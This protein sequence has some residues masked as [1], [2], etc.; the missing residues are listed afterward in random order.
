MILLIGMKI[1]PFAQVPKSGFDAMR[2]G[3]FKGRRSSIVKCIDD[4]RRHDARLRNVLA[5]RRVK[6]SV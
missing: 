6:C 1:A 2:A 4:I 5:T 3:W